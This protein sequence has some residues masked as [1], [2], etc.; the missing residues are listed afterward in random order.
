MTDDAI[1]LFDIDEGAGEPV[2]LLIHGFCSGKED[3]EPQIEAL[4]KTNRVIAPD[5][6]GHGASPRGSAEMTIEQLAADCIAHVNAKGVNH[7]VVAGHSM[8]TRVALE[9]ARQAPDKVFGLL[10]VDGSNGA[11]GQRDAAVQAF[12]DTIAADG[13]EAFARNLFE[14]MFF[15]PQ[16]EGL[17]E[18]LVARALAVPEETARPLYRNMTVWDG[19]TAETAIA[20]ARVPILALQSTTRDA[21][22][23]RSLERDE[24]GPYVELVARNAPQTEVVLFPGLGHFVTREAPEQVNV[25]IES[26]ARSFEFVR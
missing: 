23:R 1:T 17:A 9:I 19:D 5:L 12:E 25:A 24:R 20:D 4:A 2:F 11:A 22:G 16:H 10:L 6:R 3:W 13:F 14:Q 26:W 15:D 7:M 8:G 18:K 21:N